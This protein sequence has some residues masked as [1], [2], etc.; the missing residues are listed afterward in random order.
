MRNSHPVQNLP[1]IQ[2]SRTPAHLRQGGWRLAQD[3]R[4]VTGRL[5]LQMMFSNFQFSCCLITVPLGAESPLKEK[6]KEGESLGSS[7]LWK[8]TSEGRGRH[9]RS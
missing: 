4:G 5:R 9:L 3:C 6:G 8:E 7:R 2:N 1:Q